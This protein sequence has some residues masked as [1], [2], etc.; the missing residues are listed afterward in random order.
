MIEKAMVSIA[1]TVMDYQLKYFNKLTRSIND[2]TYKNL[3]LVI[4]DKTSNF[5]VRDL[6]EKPCSIT[7]TSIITFSKNAGFAENYNLAINNSHGEHVFVLNLD[8][9]LDS[10]CI[11]KLVEAMDFDPQI[12][13][14]S[15]KI[16]R[17]DENQNIV[18]PRIID[19]CG[20]YFTRIIRH[21]DRGSGEIDN[22]QYDQK[23]FVFGVTG[24]GAFYRK[25]CLD[26]IMFNNQYYDEDFWSYREDAD[27]SWRINNYGWKCFYTPNALMYHVR[28]LKPGKRSNNSKVSNMHSVK[29]RYLLLTNNMSFKNYVLNFP[30]I[31]FRDILVVFGILVKE[32]YSLKAFVYLIT[33]LKYILQK[34][35]LLQ[36]KKKCDASVFWFNNRELV[37]LQQDQNDNK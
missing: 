16:L 31:L 9:I 1:L 3:E 4:I 30:F 24:A 23:C 34:R 37:L 25:T 17:L 27:I 29:N 12:G 20:M 15:P 2:Q 18:T 14:A 6:T 21:L 28:T 8:T 22:G 36:R 11:E 33:N 19:S 35:K 13:C 26:D 10:Q 7:N 5:I 32:H